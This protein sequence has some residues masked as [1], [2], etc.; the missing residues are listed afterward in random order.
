MGFLVRFEIQ[1]LRE[2]LKEGS[3]THSPSSSIRK[4]QRS[5]CAIQ[6]AETGQTRCV[7]GQAIEHL[8]ARILLQSKRIGIEFQPAEV[9]KQAKNYTQ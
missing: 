9:F 6:L 5:C 2:R 8:L 4:S 1:V 7:D 3:D